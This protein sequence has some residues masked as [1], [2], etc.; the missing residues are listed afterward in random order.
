ME[1]QLLV[2]TGT[3]I[4][5]LG[6]SQIQVEITGRCN[7]RCEHCRASNLLKKDMPIEQII[8]I[9][10][11]SLPLFSGK[12]E[13]VISGGEPLIHSQFQK[14]MEQI[15]TNGIEYGSLTTNGWFL[16]KEH[17][18]LV[19][20]LQF[21][22]FTFSVSIDNM[23]PVIHDQ[24][25]GRKGSFDKAK[26]ALQLLKEEC[27]IIISSSV[28]STILASDIE[29]MEEIVE[30]ARQMSCISVGFSAV[31]PAGKAIDN[32]TLWMTR[33]QKKEFI[34][35]IYLL[36]SKY[37]DISIGTTD[38]LKCLFCEEETTQ[39]D[40]MIILDGCGAALTTFNINSNGEMTPCALLDIP[41]MNIFPLTIDEIM[42]H[43]Q[44]SEIVKNLL[45]RNFKGKC[46]HCSQRYSCG[47]CRAR[48]HVQQ[49]SYLGSD[50]HCWRK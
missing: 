48:A 12:K 11:F 24:F 16:T 44:R 43:Y 25:R 6:F 35:R 45:L 7:L 14:V 26:Q 9:I 42:E 19:K 21:K 10:Q 39:Q 22:G 23:N 29:K 50:P 49:G 47:G 1:R 38:P 15:R 32:P 34:Q 13:M 46:G 5:Q 20:R 30:F 3:Q 37:A 18:E 31:H 40:E 27:D 17:I 2:N 36:N 33:K 41:I 4:F 8:K 28:R